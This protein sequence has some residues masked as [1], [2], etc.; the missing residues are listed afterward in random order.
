MD[1]EYDLVK[2]FVDVNMEHRAVE[3][4]NREFKGKKASFAQW[5]QTYVDKLSKAIIN[6]LKDEIEK[7]L[8]AILVKVTT[9]Y[10]DILTKFIVNGLDNN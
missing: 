1:F 10:K 2:N 3:I 5:E 4:L 7:D 8:I 9:E 6:Q